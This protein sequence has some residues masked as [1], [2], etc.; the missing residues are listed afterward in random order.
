VTAGEPAGQ[1]PSRKGWIQVDFNPDI[2][3]PCP[4]V[5]PDGMN[6]ESWAAEYSRAWWDSTGRK[7]S[8][9]EISL[10]AET[11]S[12]IQE[13]AY[14]LLP[15]HLAFIHLPN[16]AMTPLLVCY[17]VWPA[18]GE[19][20]RQQRAARPGTARAEA[21]AALAAAGGGWHRLGAHRPLPAPLTR[22][23]GRRIT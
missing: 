7:N 5:F 16:P 6:R 2:W 1:L 12:S 3:I 18:L 9:R 13:N 10:L 20:Q 14:R 8:K 15:C 23:R 11:L 21:E 22:M 4:P 19:R 17:A